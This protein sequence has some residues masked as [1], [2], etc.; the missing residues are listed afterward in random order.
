MAVATEGVQ[1]Q[2]RVDEPY[3]ADERVVVRILPKHFIVFDDRGVR[4]DQL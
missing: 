4:L 1:V 3:E 2:A